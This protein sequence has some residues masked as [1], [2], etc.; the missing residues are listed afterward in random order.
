MSPSLALRLNM[1]LIMY[2]NAC[3]ER[4]GINVIEAVIIYVGHVNI[5]TKR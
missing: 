5:I 1:S 2:N 3:K 4:D